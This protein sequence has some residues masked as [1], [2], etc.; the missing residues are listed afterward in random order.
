MAQRRNVIVVD[1][2]SWNCDA[3][4]DTLTQAGF[5]AESFLDGGSAVRAARVAPRPC[6]LVV[7][8]MMPAMSGGE[9]IDTLRA[10]PATS[11]LPVVTCSA[12]MGAI[13]S[14]VAAH[15]PKPFSIA[16]LL[17]AIEH[18]FATVAERE[19]HGRHDER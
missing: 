7:D 6:V 12:G 8:L 15:I 1:D 14:G 2:D 19:E 3:I 10:D 16:E 17:T 11:D 18:A 13:P 4:A 5:A 9:L